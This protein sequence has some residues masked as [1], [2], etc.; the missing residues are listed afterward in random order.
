MAGRNAEHLDVMPTHG[1]RQSSTGLIYLVCV[2][3]ALVEGFGV[4]SGGMEAPRFAAEFHMAPDHVG[5]VFLLTSL[6][7]AVGAS[8]GGWVGDRVGP[9]RAMAI[10]LAL[11]GIASI[12]SALATSEAM[13]ELTRTLVG[14]GLG[15][16]LPNMIALMTATG[17]AATAPRR[18]MLSTASLSVGTLIVG[19]IT[20][21]A[22]QIGWR[23]MFHLGG[24]IA[25]LVGA[26]V[27]FLLPKMPHPSLAPAER[28]NRTAT[29]SRLNALFGSDH[30]F[31]TLF[32][33]LAFFVTAATSY[34]LLNWMPTFMTHAGLN[35]HQIGL[36]MIGLSIGGALGPMVLAS[37]LRPGRI[38]P[39]VCL[40]YGGI[41]L[42]LVLVITAPTVPLYLSFAIGFT[43]FFTG[44][45]Q[46]ILFG[47]VGT[48]YPEAARG[49]GVG[50][51]VAIGRIGS[52]VGPGLAGVMLTA[53]LTQDR[54]LAAVVPMLVVALAALLILLR[55][56]P[57]ALRRPAST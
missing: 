1:A 22:K 15:G 43:G 14:F 6:G 10:A 56:P 13:L 9:G 26:T 55:N 20:L 42:G 32:F 30:L 17:P 44:G 12:G 27:W 57:Q 49:T 45:T 4:Q 34:L 41:V 47:I 8:F 33:W 46:A 51:S 36:G 40:A 2:V 39:V 16:T 37:L 50:S 21:F 54:V 7:L 35:R 3:V 38:V 53:G 5:L 48:F 18:V 25:L 23:T 19:L 11:C 31:I 52:G 24:W 28:S 29:G